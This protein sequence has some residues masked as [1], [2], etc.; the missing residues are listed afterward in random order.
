MKRTKRHLSFLL[1]SS[2]LWLIF[3]FAHKALAYARRVIV[4]AMENLL[5]SSNIAKLASKTF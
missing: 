3:R 5:M 1:V 2:L 4:V